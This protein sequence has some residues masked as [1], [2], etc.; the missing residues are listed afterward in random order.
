MRGIPPICYVF[1]CWLALVASGPAEAQRIQSVSIPVGS[2]D[3][4]SR[5][6]DDGVWTVTAPPYPLD[7]RTGIGA[8]VNP[9][10]LPSCDNFVLHDHQYL[11]PFVP[12][13]ARAVVTFR[14]D[15][16]TIVNAVEV[17]QHTNGISQVEGFVGDET[18]SLASVGAFVWMVWTAAGAIA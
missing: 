3:A 15:Q 12:D 5:P 6:L 14:F 8:L 18:E 17:V 11:E 13:P 7:V 10:F 16:P 1:A 4:S 9:M 2:M